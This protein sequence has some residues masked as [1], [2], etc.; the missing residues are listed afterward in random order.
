ML[1]PQFQNNAYR[2]MY[3][4]VMRKDGFKPKKCHIPTLYQTF[5]SLFINPVGKKRVKAKYHPPCACVNSCR[6][7]KIPRQKLLPGSEGRNVPQGTSLNHCMIH[8]PHTH[9]FFVVVEV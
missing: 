2:V 1:L 7:P 6:Y 5:S 9:R 3:T 8:I 4:Y